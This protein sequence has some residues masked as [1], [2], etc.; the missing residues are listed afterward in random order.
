MHAGWPY[1]EVL[2]SIGKQFPNVWLDM[3][4]AW[5]MNPVQMERILDEWLAAVPCNK[6]FAFGA[7]TRFPFM[8]VGYA[9]QARMGIS[10]VLERKVQRK[11]FDTRTAE[12]VARRIMSEN[13][14]EFFPL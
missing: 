2:G 12:F 11:E 10:N 5:A 1:S 7:D 8:M 4:W 3:C 14:L 9:T 6:I 13:A